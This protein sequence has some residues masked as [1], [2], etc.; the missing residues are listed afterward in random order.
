[1]DSVGAAKNYRKIEEKGKKIKGGAPYS[2]FKMTHWGAER[3]HTET[4][5]KFLP[6]DE[7]YD[8]VK[9]IY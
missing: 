3:S 9:L 7:Y 5:S 1:M 4:A 6:K 2:S 8:D